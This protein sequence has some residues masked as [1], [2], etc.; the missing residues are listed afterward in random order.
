MVRN[1]YLLLKPPRRW[2]FVLAKSLGAFR[3][4]SPEGPEVREATGEAG[5]GQPGLPVRGQAEVGT[6]GVVGCL[7]LSLGLWV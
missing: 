5:D 2:C 7:S 3:E 6:G 1:P 4:D